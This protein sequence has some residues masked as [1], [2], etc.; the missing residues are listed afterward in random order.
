[1]PRR[2]RATLTDDVTFLGAHLVPPEYEG[3]PD[4]YVDLVCTTM[5]E[6]CAPAAR[7]IDVF[8]ERGAFDEDQARA[9]LAAGRAAGLGGRI[10]ANQLEPG[11][12]VRVAVD[13]GAASADHC[14][15]LTDADIEALAGSDTVAT[16]LP[17]SDFCTRQPYPPAR[18]RGRRRGHH[19]ARPRT[20]IQDRATRPRCPSCLAL[21]VREMGLSVD[22]ALQAATVG[23][24]RALRR[25]D[26]GRLAPGARAHLAVL[27][28]PS[29]THLAY[30]PGVPIVTVAMV[31]GA[32]V[33]G[34]P[35][36]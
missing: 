16:F 5:L 35:P 8:C 6:R 9:V 14:T 36:G 27:D 29:Y 17:A 22:E 15:H 2:R 26:L 33:V 34:P 24:A 1:M 20:A 32:V 7:W 12:G 25:D 18:R 4:A 31:G 23:G 10:H 3:R 21:A 13:T 11:A 30:R 19:R 28:A